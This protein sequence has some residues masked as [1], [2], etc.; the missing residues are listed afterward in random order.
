[1]IGRNY[2]NRKE[3]KKNNFVVVFG[4]CFYLS[5]YI[6]FKCSVF[7]LIRR[8]LLRYGFIREKSCDI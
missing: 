5:D 2:D 6:W 1:M 3:C 4:F 7:K 8:L